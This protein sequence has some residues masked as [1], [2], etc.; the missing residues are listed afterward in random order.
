MTSSNVVSDVRRLLQEKRAGHL[1]TLDPGA[2]GVLPVSLGR[3][4]RLFDYLVD[5]DKTYVFEVLFGVSTDTLDS[6]GKCVKRQE[7]S[8]SGSDLENVIPRFLGEQTQIAPAFSAVKVGGKKLYDLARSGEEIPERIRTIR[9]GSIE[10]LSHQNENR[11]LLRAVC[12]RGTYIRVL[13][14][15]IGK[16]LGVPAC[17]T[18]G[19]RPFQDRRRGLCCRS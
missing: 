12:S 14:E 6:Y 2:S 16:A 4:N 5:K 3:A 18:L 13:A 1:G 15:D 7:C 17:V 8:V 9:I 19:F 11:F 10:I